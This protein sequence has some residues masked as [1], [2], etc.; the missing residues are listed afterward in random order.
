M[1]C[2]GVK[3]SSLLGFCF[4]G[5]RECFYFYFYFLNT[6]LSWKIIK[7]SNPIWQAFRESKKKSQ[8]RVKCFNF[9][10]YIDYKNCYNILHSKSYTITYNP[11][12][13]FPQPFTL[14]FTITF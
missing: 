10:V 1:F 12:S 2:L 9:I 8:Q 3:E 4:R 13:L 6:M 7:A 5:E 11:L 14:S